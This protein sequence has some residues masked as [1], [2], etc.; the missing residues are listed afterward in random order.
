MAKIN[1]Y[2]N[3]KGNTE[4][5]FNFYQILK[6]GNMKTDKIIYWSTTI[7]FAAFMMFSAVPKLTKVLRV[8]QILHK[9]NCFFCCIGVAKSLGVIEILVPGFPRIKKWAKAGLAFD[10]IGAMYSMF[11]IGSLG[12]GCTFLF[13]PLLFFSCVL[14]LPS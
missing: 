2:L 5:A 14:L 7:P 3:F 6:S 1:P 13:L 12:F 9:V 8:T 4:E 10:L 11:A